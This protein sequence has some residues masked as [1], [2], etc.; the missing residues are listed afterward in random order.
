MKNN[1]TS[2]PLLDRA[3]ISVLPIEMYFDN[4][5]GGR[6]TC[7]LWSHFNEIYIVTNW[8]NLTGRNRLT[9]KNNSDSA[10]RP[11]RIAIKGI[12]STQSAIVPDQIS[13]PLQTNNGYNWLEHPEYRNK[14]DVACLR[15]EVG[16]DLRYLCLNETIVENIR[17]NVGDEVFILGF[18][19]NISTDGFP[20]WKRA[21][22]ATEPDHNFGHLPKILVDTASISGMSGSPVIVRKSADFFLEDKTHVLGGMGINYKFVGVYSGRLNL[23]EPRDPQLGEVWKIELVDEIIRHQCPADETKWQWS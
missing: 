1:T 18:P 16:F 5:I 23:G 17:V 3:S 13:I 14:V 22:I 11:N 21:S 10:L 19:L 9:G 6:G 8:H 4:Q 20:I 2:M 15:V 12:K 7:F